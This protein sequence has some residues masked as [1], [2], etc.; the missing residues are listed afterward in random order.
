MRTFA[1]AVLI[2]LFPVSLFSQSYASLKQQ[3]KQKSLL[4]PDQMELRTAIQKLHQKYGVDLVY[5][6]KLLEGI[7]IDKKLINLKKSL[8]Y[9]LQ[10]VVK[11]AGL[12]VKKL[13]AN[14]YAIVPGK[15]ESTSTA[16][17]GVT[18]DSTA[19][20]GLST[21]TLTASQELVAPET[22]VVEHVVKGKVTNDMNE[23]LP[24]V[25][26]LLKGTTIGTATDSEGQYALSLPDN[27]ATGRL[28]FSFI[29]YTSEELAI[30][31]QTT[32]NVQLMPDI[33]SLTEVVVVGYGTKAKRDL[34]GSISSLGGEEIVNSR[35]TNAQEALQGRAAGVDVKR[36]SGWPG[37][38]MVIEI[39]GANSITGNTQPLYVVDGIVMGNI[40]EINPADIDKIDI[41]KDA[42]STAIYGSRGANGVV[43]VTTKRGVKGPPKI[44][45]D[46]YVGV[47]NPYNLPKMMDGPK[48]VEDAREFFNTQAAS[49]NQPTPV[50]DSKIF[51]AT[52]LANIASGSYTDWTKLIQRNGIQSNHNLSVS[53]GNEHA[54]YFI[55]AGYQLYQGTIKAEDAKRYT[56]KAGVDNT[57]N[58]W[59]KFGA[60][61]IANYSDFTPGSG[62][63]FR[64]SYRLRPTGS[65]YN[66]DGTQRFFVYEGESQ[67]T[68]PLFDLDNEI[69]K[70]QYI[71]LVP[72]IYAEVTLLKDIKLRSS[73]TPDLLFQRTGMY[74]DMMSKT[75]AGTKPSSGQNGAEHWFNYTLDNLIT[76]NKVIGE[77]K[78]DATLGNSLNYYQ[79]DNNVINVSGLPYKSLW[80]NV[81]SVT[82]TTINGNVVQPST[83][84][85]SY[86]SKQNLA[87]FFFR[88]NYAF[89]NR[90]LLTLTGRY[91]GN[92]IFAKGN[93]WGFFPSAG[94]AWIASDESFMQNIPAINLLKFRFSY[95]QSGNA[96]LSLYLYPYVTQ[97]TVGTTLYDFNGTNANGF[98]PNILANKNL[99]WEKTTEYNGGVEV[100]LLDNRIA[101]QV[102]LYRKASKGSI[103]SQRIP[104]ANGF[105]SVTTNLGSVQN[106]GVEVGL[107]TVN[108]KTDRFSWRSNINFAR[109]KNK[110]VELYGDGKDDIG[111]ARFLGEKVRVVYNYKVLGVWQTSEVAEA[112]AYG[113]KPGQW[114][115]EDKNNDGKINSD[116]RQINGSDIPD[117]FGGI[118]NTFNYANFDLAVT[119]YTRQGT[120]QQSSFLAQYMNGDQG[121]A[122]FNAF[123]RAYWTPANPSNEWANVA[124]ETD[125]SRRSASEFMNSSYTKISNMTLGYTFPKNVL[126]RSAFKSLR[127]YADAFNPFIFTKFK[128]WDPETADLNSFG[129]QDFRTRTFMLGINVSL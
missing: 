51:S 95:G 105:G 13:K 6:E 69:R 104:A 24:G 114:K 38:D 79:Y 97:S 28:V 36:S 88:T 116:D 47:V 14:A 70:R 110:I 43:I 53:G 2:G 96:A 41:L 40:N 30:N 71:K 64:S 91:D 84:V 89:K 57:L 93:K 16:L 127:I 21:E 4:A 60:S 68:N 125:G 27:Q 55:S 126:G 78:F 58:K 62:E 101:L 77:H 29:G 80:Y 90:Y 48:F 18:T 61:V 44:S 35:A 99:T 32:L 23:P 10:T 100:N 52:E 20:I 34:T 129:L 37:S 15:K 94:L 109:N 115:I 1:V 59:L 76:Y 31:N 98:V 119:I 113:Q 86:Y 42:S 67:I 65:A 81:G 11:A 46:A 82:A 63:A 17:S 45:Y 117:W 112:A 122:R 111:N 123:D 12:G 120:F 103:L 75:N 19:E 50:A 26:V 121:R 72:N 5:E 124:I 74:A 9:N 3:I 33:K 107:N 66:A 87:S 92:S 49:N 106:S 83:T 128:G 85:G 56:L 25:S 8:E 102:D 39:R 118:T 22:K 108:I 73:F 54:V 7:V